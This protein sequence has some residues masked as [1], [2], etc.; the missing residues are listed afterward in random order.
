MQDKYASKSTWYANLKITYFFVYTKFSP[1]KIFRHKC[2]ITIFYFKISLS[3]RHDF[4]TIIFIKR[5]VIQC[6]YRIKKRMVLG[7]HTMLFAIQ[8]T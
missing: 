4:Y 7:N 5:N 8:N 6:L 1:F 2:W 3:N